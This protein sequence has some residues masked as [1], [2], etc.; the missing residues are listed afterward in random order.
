MQTRTHLRLLNI[1]LL[2]IL[3]VALCGCYALRGSSGSGRTQFSPPRLVNPADIAL[4]AGYRIDTVMTGLNFPT[5]VA[6]DAHGRIYVVESGYT[7]SDGP[8]TPRL[9]RLDRTGI[10]EIAVGDSNGPWTGLDV[11]GSFIYVAEGGTQQGGRILQIHPDGTTNVLVD[12]LPSFGD[13]QTCGP[14]VKDDWVYFGQGAATNS[15]VVGPDNAES[16]WLQ[17]HPAFHDIPAQDI[18][19]EGEN[20]TTKNALGATPKRVSTGAYR[21][22]GTPSAAGRNGARR[23][24]LHGLHHARPHRR[25]RA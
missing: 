5:G 15:G 25:Q 9:L 8:T 3:M 6:F 11:A 21:P 7:G 19:L 16:G 17:R 20:F 13:Y 23:V 1:T 18:V 2:G 14:V 22:Y 10:A 12:S 24:A 4:P